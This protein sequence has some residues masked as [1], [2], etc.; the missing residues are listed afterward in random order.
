MR[1]TRRGPGGS[2]HAQSILGRGARV[3]TSGA[4]SPEITSSRRRGWSPTGAHRSAGDPRG[5]DVQRERCPSRS[6]TR[7]P[8]RACS[9]TDGAAGGKTSDRPTSRSGS[10]EWH[11]S[12]GL[13]G[14]ARRGFCTLEQTSSASRSGARGD[15]ATPSARIPGRRPRGKNPGI[16]RRSGG[17]SGGDVAADTSDGSAGATS[18]RRERS[19]ARRVRPRSRSRPGL[20]RHP[21]RHRDVAGKKEAGRKKEAGERWVRRRRRAHL[22]RR[23]PWRDGGR[24]VRGR[25][26]GVPRP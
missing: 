5:V 18:P 10:V 20:Q 19:R 23:Y 13:P 25:S 22:L 11:R 2:P 16:G 21:G 24:S 1:V 3:H 26:Q 9:E 6:A 15:R 17:R 7:K 14:G 12:V 4:V 8:P